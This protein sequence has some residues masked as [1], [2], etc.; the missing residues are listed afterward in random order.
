[1]L[2]GN[3][4]KSYL[5]W[6]IYRLRIIAG[7]QARPSHVFQVVVVPACKVLNNSRL[8]FIITRKAE[9]KK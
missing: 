9:D 2:C 6:Q 3:H 7:L 1:M 8:I 5:H 4:C